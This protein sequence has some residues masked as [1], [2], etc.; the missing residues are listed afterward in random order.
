M[1]S[2]WNRIGC[3]LIALCSVG[4]CVLGWWF[5]QL[6]PS[7][8]QTLTLPRE[9]QW[10]R[11]VQKAVDRHFS[12]LE[13]GLVAK[14][15]VISIKQKYL[16]KGDSALVER[17]LRE[18]EDDLKHMFFEIPN[19]LER[20]RIIENYGLRIPEGQ[21]DMYTFYVVESSSKVVLVSVGIDNDYYIR[22][23]AMKE[24]GREGLSG[25]TFMEIMYSK[26]GNHGGCLVPT[27]GSFSIFL[28]ETSTKSALVYQ[29]LLRFEYSDQRQ[30]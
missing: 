24:G 23:I 25:N 14:P 19:L 12:C 28:P 30:N 21:L 17:I 7:T 15:R 8:L 18:A 5:I 26:F 29:E 27:E 6:L 1:G 13:N 11:T 4:V 3:I 22:Y 20:H 9:E 10:K 16:R 2:R